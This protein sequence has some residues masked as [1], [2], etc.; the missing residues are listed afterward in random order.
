[1]KR[2]SKIA[3]VLAL[4]A[5]TVPAGAQA[6]QRLPDITG[7]EAAALGIYAVPGVIEAAKLTCA[8]RLSANGFL[9]TRGDSLARRYAAQQNAA[10]PQARSAM[11][12]VAGARADEQLKMF[13]TLPDNA[14]RPLVD[15]LIRQEAAARVTPQSCSYIE[16]MAEALAPL[17]PAQAGRI[18]G[19]LFDI[20]STGNE[21]L[22]RSGGPAARP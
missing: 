17:E 18:L 19:V 2:S 8:G 13:A 6:Q 4:A 3:A 5:L 21:L 9:A 1:M 16:R 10:W 12:K 14:V 22:A 15:A 7:E 11:F 20:A